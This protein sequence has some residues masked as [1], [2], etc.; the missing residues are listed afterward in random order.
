MITILIAVL[1]MVVI[2]PLS[3]IGKGSGGAAGDSD[4]AARR[5]EALFGGFIGHGVL[6]H[7]SGHA[8]LPW[9]VPQGRDRAV[10]AARAMAA[11]A[12]P[13]CGPRAAAAARAG[14]Q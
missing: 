10:A 2:W 12:R 5:R 11:L 3:M 8:T 14:P 4:A 1:L 13:P 6:L 9:P 7:P